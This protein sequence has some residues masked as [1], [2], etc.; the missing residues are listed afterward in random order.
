ML[1]L[2]V[3]QCDRCHT[4][5]RPETAYVTRTTTLCQACARRMIRIP[6]KAA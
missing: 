4:N 3:Q 6:P 2:T 5:V 1:M